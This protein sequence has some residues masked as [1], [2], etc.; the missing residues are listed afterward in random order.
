[1]T[2]DLPDSLTVKSDAGPATSSKEPMTATKAA[3]AALFVVFAITGFS[4]LTL[5][6]VWQRV[7]S[8]HAGVDLV[9]FTTVV[10]A[11]LAGLGVGSLAGGSLADRLGPHR[12]V[13]AFAASNLAIGAFAWGS[14]WVFYDLYRA[15]AVHLSAT[16]AKFAFNFALLLVPTM[17][18]GLSTPLAAKSIVARVDEAGPLVG[19]LYAVNTL[20]AAAG[21]AVAGWYLLGAVG[22]TATTRVAGSLNVVAAAGLLVVA[23]RQARQPAADLGPVKGDE[24][25]GPATGPSRTAGDGPQEGSAAVSCEAAPLTVFGARVWPWYLVYALTG[26][27]ALG[28][29]V[30]FFRVIDT[31]MR[32]NSYSF[33]HVLSLYLLLFGVGAAIA[34]PVVKRARR[35]DLWFC[36]IQFAV[37]ASALVGLILMI[38]GLPH[39]PLAD[40]A[41]EHFASEGLAVGF[42]TIDGAPRSDLVGVL[43]GLP[44]LVMAVP[45]LCMGAGF[46]FVQAMV[47]DRVDTL[48]RHTGRLLFANIAGNVAGTLVVGFF[49]LDRLGT[50][51]T[52]RIL[53]IA[54][55]VPALVAAWGAK[56][57][58]PVRR[59]WRRVGLAVS[60]C[61]VMGAILVA[62]PSNQSIYA[63][64]HGVPTDQLAMVEDRTCVA[65]L[66]QAAG[67]ERELTVNASVQN[68]Y[69]FDDF[70]VLIGL[71][72][73]VIHPRPQSAMALGL[74]IGATP[75]GLGLSNQVQDISTVEICGG[76]LG[77]LQGLKDE[78][79]SDVRRML[80]NPRQQI[81]VGDG[82]DFLL[83]SGK[84]FDVVVVDTL[85]SHSAFSGS[86]YSV[87]FYE[88]VK[89]HLSSGGMLA[90]WEA[91]PRV[92]NSMTEVFPYVI[93]LRVWSYFGSKYLIASDQPI[94]FDRE[95][96][97]KRVRA[98]AAAPG[99]S[100]D[101]L[102]RLDRLQ[103]FF[104]AA[105]VRCVAD[106]SARPDLDGSA[107]NR[108][109]HPR[110]EYFLNNAESAP[111]RV[112]CG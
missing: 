59:N 91:S 53:G 93:E 30:V 106:G 109:L 57:R 107:L 79:R 6:V 25:A 15:Q 90:Q 98:A 49:M 14:L 99:M 26:A 44:A 39:T 60:A 19:R 112:S 80:D 10:A 50:S 84:Q 111:R 35:K 78:G 74:G 75:Y 62:V 89:S 104:R 101:E 20:G 9:S 43:F 82:R 51:R 100:P 16:P 97:I 94:T 70:H 87:E 42:S 28:F 3:K 46:P 12:S 54:L 7:M 77:L 21:S 69:P 41:R 102:G 36:W 65:G 56:G 64:L 27:V 92:V 37:G 45:V 86:L 96:V 22:F 105:E 71:T 73:T 108:D 18:M 13:T 95:T 61:M 4:A 5:Q 29:E 33:A 34:A 72:P 17:L 88:L 8:L 1:M 31:A 23:R 76:E 52:Y 2:V 38:K 47:T 68:N 81:H 66:R 24:P 11:F 55:T 110:D 63:T 103:E 48:G 83:R 40:A 58:S 85:R 32:S 67:G